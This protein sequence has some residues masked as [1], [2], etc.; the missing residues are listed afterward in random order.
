MCLTKAEVHWVS[1]G[2]CLWCLCMYCAS[3]ESPPLLISDK[4]GYFQSQSLKLFLSPQMRISERQYKKTDASRERQ[5]E[6]V[7]SFFLYLFFSLFI[8]CRERKRGAKKKYSLSFSLAGYQK[9][10][11]ESTLSTDN[12]I[13]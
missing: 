9:S 12:A 11:R 4:F 1:L 3:I 2:S 10:M 7:K 5:R 13:F 6:R 8:S